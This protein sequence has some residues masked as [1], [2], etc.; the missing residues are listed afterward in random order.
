M[1]L[2]VFG[3]SMLVCVRPLQR[4]G[5]SISAE[6]QRRAHNGSPFKPVAPD[7]PVTFGPVIV[8]VLSDPDWTKPESCLGLDTGVVFNPGNPRQKGIDLMSDSSGKSIQVFDLVFVPFQNDQFESLTPAAVV[9]GIR[10]ATTLSEPM[11]T[12]TVTNPP[13]TFGFK[14]REGGLGMLQITGFTEDL[15]AV[16]VR[17]K[18]IQPPG[19]PPLGPTNR[20]SGIARTTQARLRQFERLACW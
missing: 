8:R 6:L 13:S 16:S 4:L 1:L 18:L 5:V 11:E 20:V 12:L 14:T 9:D 2:L 19:A 3:A 10:G 17:Y 7:A 15:R